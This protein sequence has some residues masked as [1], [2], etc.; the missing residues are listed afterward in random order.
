MSDTYTLFLNSQNTTG[1]VNSANL[2]AYQ[3]YINW[4]PI[5]QKRWQTFNL[6]FTLKSVSNA[7]PQT[8]NALVSINFGQSNACQNG[9]GTS[10]VIG[11]C[12]PVAYQT[13]GNAWQYYYN[14]NAGDN[15]PI[16]ISYPT[17]NIITVTFQNFDLTTP[18]VM[19]HYVLELTFT[20]SVPATSVIS[21]EEGR[22][23]YN[24][25]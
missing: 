15:L 5:L 11:Y 2:N 18:F 22:H 25:L 23:L 9:G 4:A 3:Y 12:Y 1:I 7:T 13:A 21:A 17:N 14:C 6:S 24:K 16:T 8:A 20:P 19:L 10:N